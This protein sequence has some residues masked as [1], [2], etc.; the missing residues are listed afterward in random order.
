M[1]VK[2]MLRESVDNTVH[3]LK[4]ELEIRKGELEDDWH[5]SSLEKIFIENRIYHDIEDSPTWEHTIETIDKGL[6]PFKPLLK[7][8]V[9][10][11]DIE[12]LT[13]IK[14]KRITKHD[15]Y[16]ANEHI[17]SI[18]KEIEEINYKL[19]HIID[20]AIEYYK[21][22]KKKYGKGKERKT[23]IRNFD[24]IVA[25]K[26]VVANE[27][28][29]VN[30]KEGFI[31][32][33]LKKDEFVCECSDIDD[34]IIFMKDGK[35]VVT[36]VSEK[37]FIG[38]NIIH[39]N[40]FRKD[41][42]R[43]VYNVIYRDGKYGNYYM[44]RF[45]VKSIT[46]DKIYDLTKGTKDSKVM[47]F[48]ANPN[49]EAE[50]V[51]IQL[52]PKPKLRKLNLELDFSK[53]SIKGR[54]SQGNILTKNEIHKIQLKEKGVSTLGGRKI[55]FNP[56]V[57]RLNTDEHGKYL[58]E[59]Q[60]NDKILVITADGKFR[61]TNFDLTNHFKDN[62][63]YIEKYKKD[64]TFSVAHYDGEQKNY[65]IKRFQLIPE[66]KSGNLISESSRSKLHILSVH[67]YPQFELTFGGS[68]KDKA[69]E[70]IDIEQFISIKSYKARGN[71]ASSKHVKKIKEIEPLK[72]EN[73]LN[74]STPP[75]ENDVA[76]KAKE[77]PVRDVTDEE[78]NQLTLE[79]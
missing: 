41:D 61:F 7:R 14:M 42:D 57:L 62:I 67:K 33:S 5:K 29:Y 74:S 68:D 44:K 69:P 56:D 72:K 51:K 38:K 75:N 66:D 21:D 60:G 25:T 49:G 37:A 73:E 22:I 46:R 50:I 35:Y 32:T 19:A 10:T 4:R 78:D 1:S 16:K 59:F 8:T 70:I 79:L 20:Y 26:V 11:E 6:E 65:Y 58:G 30:R 63:I 24:N 23:E 40:I 48:T 2:D 71:K 64:I 45:S 77:N 47:Y 76:Q 13:E 17:K 18:E 36:K 31:G 34:V 52:K 28:L 43:T 9:T 3:L 54:N 15:A 53:L 12:R 55:W 27:K 39:L